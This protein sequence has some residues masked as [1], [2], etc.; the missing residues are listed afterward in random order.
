MKKGKLIVF[1]G[2][3]GS[4]KATQI[5]LLAESFKKL[6]IPNEVISFP[7]YGQNPYANLIRDYLD[8]KFDSKIDPYIF[9]LAFAIDRLL[10]KSKIEKWLRGGEIVLVDRYVASNKAHMGAQLLKEKR[11]EFIKWLDNLEYKTNKMPKEDL[12]IFLYVPPEISIGNIKKEERDLYEKDQ[13]HQR[14][15]SKIYLYLA[16]SP[17]WVTINCVSGGKMR[18]KENIQKEILTIVKKNV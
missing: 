12:V 11:K 7:R 14:D 2:T 9:S 10:A 8:G 6:K 4:G 5:N 15:S 16:K 1:E 17:K 13:K 18:G 3:D